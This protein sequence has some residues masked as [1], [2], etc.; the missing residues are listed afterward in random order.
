MALHDSFL[1]QA[2]KSAGPMS[3]KFTVLARLCKKMD[4]HA[5]FLSNA[6]IMKPSAPVR[7]TNIVKT[8]NVW[9][10]V[11]VFLTDNK[12]LYLVG[13]SEEIRFGSPVRCMESK[14][15]WSSASIAAHDVFYQQK[16]QDSGE[17]WTNK[18]MELKFRDFLI[19]KNVELNLKGPIPPALPTIYYFQYTGKD[20]FIMGKD[21]PGSEER[22]PCMAWSPKNDLEAFS[23]ECKFILK[24]YCQSPYKIPS[25]SVER[26]P[27]KQAHQ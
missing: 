24:E 18:S 23:W 27:W 6:R 10:A 3:E 25:K 22:T 21:N 19:N 12:H 13:M 20:C 9:I 16:T 4:A 17:T 26:C 11:N 8:G 5:Q 1:A 14:F 2:L 15:S 7:P